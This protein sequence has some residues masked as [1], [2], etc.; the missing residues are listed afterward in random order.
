MT[1]HEMRLRRSEVCRL[2]LIIRTTPRVHPSRNVHRHALIRAL[3]GGAI[4]KL[5]TYSPEKPV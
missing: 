2:L 1:A 3:Y 5:L 4:P